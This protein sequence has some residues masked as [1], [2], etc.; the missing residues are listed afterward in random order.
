[1]V[2]EDLMKKYFRGTRTRC[3]ENP[4][5]PQKGSHIWKLLKSMAPLV[6]SKI[7]WIPGNK[8]RYIDLGRQH[9]WKRSLIY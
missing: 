4:M 1:M 2:E 8:K 9:P 3:L 7:T 6:R 5:E